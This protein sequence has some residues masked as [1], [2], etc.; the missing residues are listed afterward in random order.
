MN[1]CVPAPRAG[2]GRFRQCVVRGGEAF[3]DFSGKRQRLGQQGKVERCEYA[4][5]GRLERGDTVAEA[6]NAGRRFTLLGVH[7]A[8]ENPAPGRPLGESVFTRECHALVAA[9]RGGGDIPGEDPGRAGQT[10][11]LGEGVGMAQLPAQCER[12]IGSAGRT[13]RIATMP[14]RPGQLDKGGDPDV[15]SV[16][17]SGIAVLAGPIQR[18]G[19]FGM[20]EGCTVIAA[21]DQRISEDAMA[22]QE[23][24]GRGL[25][26]G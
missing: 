22:D 19:R 20:L 8:L 16:A 18:G 2:D 4:R 24:T 7:P 12:T 23:R 5:A 6:G 1:L 10:E 11:A 25:R 9:G 21:N 26:L 15:R 3:L 13:I 17:K 14:K